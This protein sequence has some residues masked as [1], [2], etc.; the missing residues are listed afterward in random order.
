MSQT[1][2][3][4]L[5]M[6]FLYP[7]LFRHSHLQPASSTNLARFL[8]SASS[9]KRPRAESRPGASHGS[10]HQHDLAVINAARR[11]LAHEPDPHLLTTPSASAHLNPSPE[12]YSRS[13]FADRCTL[14]VQAGSGGNGCAA[15]LREAHVPDGPPNGGDGGHGGSVFIQAVR[16]H[17]SLHKLARQG[18]VKAG[19]GQ[20]GQG[21]SQSGRRGEDVCI[22]VPVGTV[23]R[24]VWRHDPIEEQEQDSWSSAMDDPTATTPLDKSR[25]VAYPGGAKR[26]RPLNNPLYQRHREERQN[27][28]VALQPPS[29]IAL[30]LASPM[31]SPQ[32]LLA[33]GIG[34]LGNPHFVTKEEPKPKIASKGLRGVEIK[35]ELE[36]KLLADVGL[37]GLP[38]AGK[39]TL[40]R[41]LSRSRTRIGEW[42]FTT[43]SPSIG[44]VVLDADEGRVSEVAE[45]RGRFTVADIPG[46]VEGASED[47]G[48]GMRFLRH[49]ERA[50]VLGFVVDL[51]RGGAVEGLKALWREVGLYETYREGEIAESTQ[52]SAGT[53]LLGEE[54][55][56]VKGE[57]GQELVSW[58]S[59]FA[60]D[61]AFGTTAAASDEGVSS[62]HGPGV[63][64]HPPSSSSRP[65]VPTSILPPISSKPWFVVATK[66]DLPGTQAEFERL[67]TY[68]AAVESRVER[69]PIDGASGQN[70]GEVGLEVRTPARKGRNVWKGRIGCIPVSA[71][72]ANNEAASAAA[73][74]GTGAGIEIE[75]VEEEVEGDDG[76]GG[77]GV[78]RVKDWVAQLMDSMSY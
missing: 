61:D 4:G 54:D 26:S 28:L 60:S 39:S 32:L 34:G 44:T 41:A 15:F 66:A 16:G 72:T 65:L 74:A 24:E 58:T 31:E 47:R 2:S 69:H 75:G 1:S 27:P 18:R 20:G 11:A 36:L 19:R 13:L 48:L 50:G 25:F 9:P 17:T 37:V 22:E 14:L 8:K 51:S 23:V 21:S 64:I 29:P 10:R 40:V 57:K 45:R 62:G 56:H 53:G 3:A 30:D 67:A 52:K 42:A 68:V 49:V 43:L 12:D 76:T 71:I 35:L 7:V 63:S 38:N 6:P 59:P 55:I 5:L 46:L 73:G 78:E 77:G 33:G 70:G